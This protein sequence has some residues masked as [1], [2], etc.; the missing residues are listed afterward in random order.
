MM[1][2]KNKEQAWNWENSSP[3]EGP[4]KF[5]AKMITA[6][7][8]VKK[9]Y[10]PSPD[11]RHARSRSHAADAQDS[12]QR[13]DPQ[14]RSVQGYTNIAWSYGDRCLNRHREFPARDPYMSASGATHRPQPTEGEN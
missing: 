9:D 1:P 10:P 14:A 3:R 2:G 7:Q 4:W 12:H 6:Y 5:K 13:V 8:D 11:G